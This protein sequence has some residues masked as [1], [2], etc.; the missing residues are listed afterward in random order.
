M[1]VGSAQLQ[2]LD[3]NGF[4]EKDRD[5]RSMSCPD[6]QGRAPTQMV[7]ETQAVRKNSSPERLPETLPNSEERVS[8][9]WVRL[10]NML[11]LQMAAKMSRKSPVVATKSGP[12]FTMFW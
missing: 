1:S 7:V 12:S 2:K 4:A 9:N 3:Q 11:M 10:R 6:L 5:S 8:L